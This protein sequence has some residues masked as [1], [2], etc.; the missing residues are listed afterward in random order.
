MPSSNSS[1]NKHFTPTLILHGGAG[2]LTP[3]NLPTSRQTSYK[4]SLLSILSSTHSLL[5]SGSSALDAAVHAVSLF[6]DN[7]LFNCGRGSVF[8]ADG[9]IEM[10][11]S[12]AVCS[13]R[14]EVSSGGDGLV[15]GAKRAA[16]VM[17]VKNVRHPIQLAKE[18]LVRPPEEGG[19]SHCQLSG[20]YVEELAKKWELEIKGDEWFWTRK[21]WEEHLKGLRG[22]VGEVRL[23]QGTVGAVCLDANGDLCVATSTGG[24]TNKKRGRIGDTPT[25]GAG[26]WA[27]GWVEEAVRKV[28]EE[29]EGKGLEGRPRSLFESLQGALESCLGIQEPTD[30]LYRPLLQPSRPTPSSSYSVPEKQAH[31]YPPK[32]H[33]YLCLPPTAPNSKHRAIAMSGTGNGDSFLRTNACRTA[34]AIS[35][36]SPTPLSEAVSRV[37]GP[38]GEL[39]KSAGDRWKVTGEGQGGIV[40]IEVSQDEVEEGEGVDWERKGKKRKGNVVF[41]FN[42]GGM[43]RVFVNGKGEPVVGIFKGDDE[44]VGWDPDGIECEIESASWREGQ[45]ILLAL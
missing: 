11:A 39:Q 14:P 35:R 44:V 41:D 36:F 28:M 24:L 12:V 43:F 27:E 22:E 4:Q 20:P 26:F 31:L 18:L 30:I 5:L 17:L 9:T 1:G 29:G 45:G 7:P 19:G 16:G 21:R 25:V 38:G 32:P 13:V 2:A 6:E 42:C 8:T 40:G 15:G 33:S 10:E 23:S 34:G 37:A 3:S